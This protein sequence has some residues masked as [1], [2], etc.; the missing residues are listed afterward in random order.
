M[1][2][3]VDLAI[4]GMLAIGMLTAAACGGGAPAPTAAPAAPT[5][6]PAAAPT[7]APTTAAAPTVAPTTAA[8]PTKA[9]AAPTTAVAPTTAAAPSA[10]AP[11]AAGDVT[12]GKAVFDQNCNACHPGG[13][14]GVGP[15]LK[16]RNLGADVIRT[17]VR[18]GKG[19][20]PPFSATQISDQQLTN[21]IAYVQSLK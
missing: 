13:D 7:A 4:A 18:S 20:M 15:A 19:S 12:A 5:K 17:T 10:A 8:A 14:K 11:A 16:G 9:A 1:R 3:K 6:A 2:P 21:L